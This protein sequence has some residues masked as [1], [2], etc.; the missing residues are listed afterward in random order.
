MQIRR[1]L[2]RYLIRLCVASA[3]SRVQTGCY[4]VGRADR[5]VFRRRQWG[6]PRT[7]KVGVTDRVRRLRRRRSHSRRTP[8]APA[9]RSPSR[10]LTPPCARALFYR[11]RENTHVVVVAYHTAYDSSRI[12]NN[13]KKKNK[14]NITVSQQIL[15]AT[16]YFDICRTTC[17]YYNSPD[18]HL[19][20]FGRLHT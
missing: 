19:A 4:G 7:T 6:G 15:A 18:D 12:I 17:V 10:S 1:V 11:S 8:P 14:K 9:I 5:P 16:R 20:V 2:Y 3:R 13:R